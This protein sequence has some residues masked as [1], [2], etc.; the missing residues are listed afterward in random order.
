VPGTRT[1]PV[2]KKD[3][4]AAITVL[5]NVV[6]VV[7]ERGAV[8]TIPKGRAVPG[9][10][11]V[12]AGRTVPVGNT[13][14]AERGVS[15]GTVKGA[16]KKVPVMITLPAGKNVPTGTVKGPVRITPRGPKMLPM[17]A[18]AGTVTPFTTV[19]IKKVTSGPKALAIGSVKME[20]IA[21]I[22]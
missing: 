22:F 8:R 2:A 1:D 15:K 4:P 5:F 18:P 16:S 6:V 12:P 10:M 3:P 14:D 20:T 19:G 11:T 17:V 13:V 9:G 7:I 21:K